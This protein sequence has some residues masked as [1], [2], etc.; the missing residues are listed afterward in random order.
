MGR[1]FVYFVEREEEMRHEQP[2]DRWIA[3]V[4]WALILFVVGIVFATEGHCAQKPKVSQRA[5]PQL[6]VAGLRPTTVTLTLIIENTDE[7]L[8]CPEVTFLYPDG[9][10]SVQEND[11]VEFKDA[12]PIDLNRQT[13]SVKVNL[14]AGDY[15][16]YAQVAKSGKVMKQVMVKVQVAG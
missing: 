1:L 9:T 15:E 2:I 11:C 14:F 6:A 4:M 13:W 3:L 7:K 16:F 5:Y 12:D 8:W 10:K